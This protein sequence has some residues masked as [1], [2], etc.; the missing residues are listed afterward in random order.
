MLL[1]RQK[2]LMDETKMGRMSPVR[3]AGPPNPA[4]C[5]ST[6]S[7][8]SGDRYLGAC[9]P[10]LPPQRLSNHFPSTA[11]CREPPFLAEFNHQEC[12]SNVGLT[13][14]RR[15]VPAPGQ[16]AFLRG[17]CLPGTLRVLRTAGN[18]TKKDLLPAERHHPSRRPPQQA[19][20]SPLPAEGTAWQKGAREGRGRRLTQ[21]PCLILERSFCSEGLSGFHSCCRLSWHVPLPLEPLRF[22]RMRTRNRVRGLWPC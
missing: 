20:V 12:G 21:W 10:P 3:G 9:P 2:V 19:Q 17:G 11:D 6:L 13:R 7:M 1:A 4:R 8:E 16:A 22:P 5:P 18:K 14:G 15:R